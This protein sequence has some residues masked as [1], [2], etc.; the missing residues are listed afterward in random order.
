MHSMR[1]A[2]RRLRST[3]KSY[4][5]VLDRSVTDPIGDELKWLAA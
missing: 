1:V 2:T 5:K 4:G 3:F